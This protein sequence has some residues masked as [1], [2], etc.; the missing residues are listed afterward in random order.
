MKHNSSGGE[1]SS[2]HEHDLKSRGGYVDEIMSGITC[3]S[4]PAAS[5]HADASLV[6]VES[7]TG[8]LYYSSGKRITQLKV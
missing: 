4:E 7:M 1:S 3:A 5:A 8:Y 6:V 2:S